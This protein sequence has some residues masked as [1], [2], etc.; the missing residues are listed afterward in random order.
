MDYEGPDQ[1]ADDFM[2]SAGDSADSWSDADDYLLN[3][4]GVAMRL[5]QVRP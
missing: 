4:I 2:S 3:D 1:A 5:R